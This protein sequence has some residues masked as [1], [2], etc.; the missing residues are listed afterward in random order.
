MTKTVKDEIKIEYNGVEDCFFITRTTIEKSSAAHVVAI[1]DELRRAM[2]QS[3]DALALMG[4]RLADNMDAFT[5][6]KEIVKN[7]TEKKVQD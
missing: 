7:G 3:Q 4:G 2:S 1:E 5:I 6:A